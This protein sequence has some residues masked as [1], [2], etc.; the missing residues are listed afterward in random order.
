MADSPL[1]SDLEAPTDKAELEQW[2]EDESQALDATLS[3]EINTI[4]TASLEQFLDGYLAGAE[5]ITAAGDFSDFDNIVP[6]WQQAVERRVRPVVERL[7]L[8]GG[9]SAAVTAPG[10]GTAPLNVASAW[11][12]IINQSAVQYATGRLPI[13]N[14]IGYEIRR[15]ISGKVADAVRSGRATERVAADIRKLA[16]TSDYRALTIA[17][18][19]IN[20]AYNNGNYEGLDA[21]GDEYR[22]VEKVWSAALDPDTRPTHLGM[23]GT[24][25]AWNE[26]FRFP[27]GTLM[28]PHDQSGPMEEWVNCR[29]ALLELYP[30]MTRPNGTRVPG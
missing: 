14:D 12:A 18:T 30:G 2:L 1:P 9:V 24:I 29:C 23:N 25:V 3:V 28:H 19:E 13:L 11:V 16:N 10:F 7:Y 22:P 15:N 5:S 17:R 8:S 27:N 20:G 6:R 21:M 4:V 26:P